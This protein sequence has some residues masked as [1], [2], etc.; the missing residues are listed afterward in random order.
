[1][2]DTNEQKSSLNRHEKLWSDNSWWGT[3][4]A[5]INDTSQSPGS[6]VILTPAHSETEAPPLLLSLIAQ[7][8]FS[9]FGMLTAADARSCRGIQGDD[10]LLR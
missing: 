4:L 5:D 9:K 8:I 2:L 7:L 6:W 1:M 3:S 10:Y